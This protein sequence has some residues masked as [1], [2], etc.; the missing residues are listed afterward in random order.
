MY[1]IGVPTKLDLDPK[2]KQICPQRVRRS[3]IGAGLLQA[4]PMLSIAL[5]WKARILI[6]QEFANKNLNLAL[7]ELETDA[8]KLDEIRLQCYYTEKEH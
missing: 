1:I 8:M 4:P 7:I 6:N 5:C 3:Y 2:W